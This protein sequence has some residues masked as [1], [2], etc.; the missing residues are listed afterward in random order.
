MALSLF[1]F[2]KHC[3]MKTT[4]I[5]SA[6]YC[7]RL[8]VALTILCLPV[9]ANA[10]GTRAGSIEYLK[11]ANGLNNIRLGADVRTL[12]LSNLPYMDGDSRVDADSCLKYAYNDEQ[13]LAMADSVNLD[14]IGI[15]T[16]KD[17][18]VNIYVFFKMSDA[19]KVLNNFISTY[20][21]FTERPDNYA[22]VYNWNTNTVNLSLNYQYKGDLGV[23]TFTSKPVENE[24][25]SDKLKAAT[26]A[27]IQA[28]QT[29]QTLSANNTVN[30]LNTG[31]EK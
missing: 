7:L 25:A 6:R 12:G 27:A 18:V 20:G 16:Y 10:Q 29:Y 24:I 4:L 15:R 11:S 30:T 5:S 14:M 31:E 22:D 23:A 13:V 1:S 17:R 9:M 3:P 19:Y 21:Q 2:R 26:L 8:A 28:D